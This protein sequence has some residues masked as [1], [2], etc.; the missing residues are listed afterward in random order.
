M[1]TIPEQPSSYDSS[2]NAIA[3]GVSERAAPLS[4]T[5]RFGRP[6]RGGGRS[7][8]CPEYP[9]HVYTTRIRDFF[10]DKRMILINDY[11]KFLSIIS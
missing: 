9:T 4:L 11:F 8:R 7:W 6:P 10:V 1:Y 5:A 3:S 2:K